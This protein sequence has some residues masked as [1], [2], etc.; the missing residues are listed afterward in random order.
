[1]RRDQYLLKRQDDISNSSP[2]V[3]PH[4]VVQKYRGAPLV[5]EQATP[6]V[7][8]LCFF[9]R[10]LRRPRWC[11]MGLGEAIA[12]A[13]YPDFRSGSASA[14][15][16]RARRG[17]IRLARALEFKRGTP[18]SG[19]H[20][21]PLNTKKRVCPKERNTETTWQRFHEHQK[22]GFPPPEKKKKQQKT[23]FAFARG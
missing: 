17:S 13:T 12:L 3:Y 5:S 1:M 2:L 9:G 7:F 18:Q 6:C 22:R 16:P 20:M 23:S 8:F 4:H 15:T 10:F 19:V 21:L 14:R 11:S